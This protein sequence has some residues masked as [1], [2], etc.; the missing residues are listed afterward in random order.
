MSPDD[1]GRLWRGVRAGSPTEAARVSALLDAALRLPDPEPVYAAVTARV[2]GRVLRPD[3]PG[4]LAVHR[5]LLALGGCAAG[6][7]GSPSST[8]RMSRS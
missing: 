5:I 1:V 2:A 4:L 8:S 3:L 6:S 7:G